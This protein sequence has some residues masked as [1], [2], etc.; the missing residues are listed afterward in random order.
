[1]KRT[2]IFGLLILISLAGFSCKNN[3]VTDPNNYSSGD[4]KILREIRETEAW[5]LIQAPNGWIYYVSDNGK[6]YIFPN[7][8]TFK[9]WF[10]EYQS[11]IKQ[12]SF[13]ELAEIEL[14]GNVTYRPGYLIQTPTDPKIYWTSFNSQL[15]PF[16]SQDIVQEIYGKNW[17][18][19]AE[20]LENFY[21]TNYEIGEAIYQADLPTVSPDLTIDQDRSFSE[22][23]RLD[24]QP[25]DTADDQT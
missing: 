4:L 19:L 2:L 1:M 13:E 16:V 3:L 22:P 5:K 21:F 10:G 17:V 12:A 14:G 24:D 6:R 25:V 11:E 20:E 8:G 9:S 18:D 15:R 7:T 23:I